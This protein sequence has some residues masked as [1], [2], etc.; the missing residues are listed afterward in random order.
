[1]VA[2]RDHNLLTIEVKKGRRKAVHSLHIPPTFWGRWYHV[3]FDFK[4]DDSGTRLSTT[5]LTSK[6]IWVKERWYH[7]AFAW[8]WR[9]VTKQK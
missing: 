8:A 6:M 7:K 5:T 2:K 9:L 4:E 1:M 3:S